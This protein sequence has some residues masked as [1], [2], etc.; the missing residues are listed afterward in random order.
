M[1]ARVRKSLD[2]NQKGFTLVELLVVVII[3]GI[4]AAIAIPVY[5]GVQ[6]NAKDSAV[7]TDLTNAKTATV[8]FYTATPSGTP[9]LANLTAEGYTKSNDTEVIR[10]DGTPSSTGFCIEAQ[11]STD[12]WFHV[13]T[14]GGVDSGECPAV[15]P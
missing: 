6:N 9:T 10:Y 13:T 5:I 14:T 15:T 12:A 8:A 7:K 4:L 2:E 3:I 11:S 1:M